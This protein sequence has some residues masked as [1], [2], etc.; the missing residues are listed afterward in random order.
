MKIL[1]WYYIISSLYSE[2]SQWQET[3]CSWFCFNRNLN[4]IL[5]LHFVIGPHK[6]LLIYRSQCPSPPPFL[7]FFFFEGDFSLSL[8]STIINS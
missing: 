6:Y 8:L 5:V 4:K 3:I 1:H 2:F 7:F